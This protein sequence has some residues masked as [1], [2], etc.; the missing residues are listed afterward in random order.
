M[1]TRTSGLVAV[2]LVPRRDAGV[3]AVSVLLQLTL[4]VEEERAGDALELAA[5]VLGP[6]VLPHR[7]PGAYISAQL[8]PCLRHSSTLHTVNTP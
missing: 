8:K 2:L 3:E 1:G 4:V 5:A 6:L 7:R